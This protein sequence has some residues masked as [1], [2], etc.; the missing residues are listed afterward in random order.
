M[1][2]QEV[3][4]SRN[5]YFTVSTE[6][7]CFQL[8]AVQQLK[9]RIIYALGLPDKPFYKINC[10][11]NFISSMLNLCSRLVLMLRGAFF[12][13]LMRIWTNYELLKACIL[14]A[15]VLYHNLRESSNITHIQLCT[16]TCCVISAFLLEE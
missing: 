2:E 3:W 13:G 5:V 4:N 1:E 14:H 11:K 9:T 10:Q 8:Q 16:Q 6:N 12:V 7:C 15:F